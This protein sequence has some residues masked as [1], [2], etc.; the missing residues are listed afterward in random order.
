MRRCEIMSD[1]DLT[2]QDTHKDGEN[3]SG[4]PEGPVRRIGVDHCE[5]HV[6]ETR[7]QRPEH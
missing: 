6:R 3:S 5:E 2:K 1:L 4:E 7:Q